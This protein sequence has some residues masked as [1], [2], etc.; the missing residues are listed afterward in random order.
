V[1]CELE[2]QVTQSWLQQAETI[3]AGKRLGKSASKRQHIAVSPGKP[4]GQKNTNTRASTAQGRHQGQHTIVKRPSK[5]HLKSPLKTQPILGYSKLQE[6]E[7][8]WQFDH[9]VVKPENKEL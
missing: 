4:W 3:V 1:H 5:T 2:S 6:I 7:M 9:N 8:A